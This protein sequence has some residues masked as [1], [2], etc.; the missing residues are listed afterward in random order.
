MSISVWSIDLVTPRPTLPP[1]LAGVPIDKKSYFLPI[2]HCLYVVN[3]MSDQ[4]GFL[5]PYIFGGHICT[6]ACISPLSPS[7]KIPSPARSNNQPHTVCNTPFLY[8]QVSFYVCIPQVWAVSLPAH[9]QGKPAQ[10]CPAVE[11]P[12]DLATRSTYWKIPKW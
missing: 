1:L 5:L 7:L 9:D 6:L 3:A 10:Y 11:L 8:H 2:C 4:F 12:W